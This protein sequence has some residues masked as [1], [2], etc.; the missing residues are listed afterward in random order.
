MK[1]LSLLLVALLAL[2]AAEARPIGE[3]EARQ[4]ASQFFGNLGQ[5]RMAKGK[6]LAP[7]KTPALAVAVSRNEFY[8][9]NDEANGGFVIVSGED[10]Q[11]V[12]RAIQ[13]L[14]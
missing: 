11:E 10:R 9:F 6:V 3:Q 14:K 5:K 7:R 2:T 8:V 1:K 13:R 4:K 12:E